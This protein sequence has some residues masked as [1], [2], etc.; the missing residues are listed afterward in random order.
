MRHGNRQNTDNRE[1]P[2]PLN[3]TL[4]ITDLIDLE[5]LQSLQDNF[6][7]ATGVASIIT[8]PD[9]TPI[10]K[11][12]NFCRLCNDI[13]RKTEKGCTNCR[14][15]DAALGQKNP[16]GPIMQ[17]CLSGGLWDGG[18]SIS[19]GNRHIA[20]WLI[21]QV[22]NSETPR[23]KL[24]LYADEIGADREEFAKAV[25]EVTVMSTEQFGR[26]CSALFV[27]AN[28]ISDLA[29]KNL[30]LRESENNLTATLKSIGDAVITTDERGR[31][32]MMNPVAEAITGWSSSDAKDR[33]VGDILPIT[34]AFTGKP[35]EDP[36]SVVLRTNAAAAIPK[37]S[38]I[39]DRNGVIRHLSDSAAPIH[40]PDGTI[41]GVVI[42]L[43]DVSRE[44]IME[45]QL[46]QSQKMD[47][48]GRLAGGIAHD[49]NNMLAGIRGAADLLFRKYKNDASSEKL[50]GIILEA[51]ER[52]ASL[53]SKMLDFSRKGKKESTPIDMHDLISRA[54]GILERSVDK[55]ISIESGLDAEQ[56]V[57]SGDPSQL[58]SVIINL[59]INA[60]DAMP[61]GGTIRISTG[62]V[63]ICRLSTHLIGDNAVP[64][65]Y[66]EICISDTG[67][68]IPRAIREKIFDPF[69]TTKETGKG[70]GLGLSV[71][72]G[73]I[74]DHR[75]SINVYS[76]EGRGSVFKIYLPLLS[77]NS[78]ATEPLIRE[79]T[80]QCRVGRILLV[81]D[82]PILRSTGQLMLEELGNE[83]VSAED[84]VQ[85]VAEI[86]GRN[87]RGI[88]LV[89]MDMIMPNMNGIEAY[90]RISDAFPEIPFIFT[91]GFTYDQSLDEITMNRNVVDFIRKPYTLSALCEALEKTKARSAKPGA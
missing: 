80:G 21:G 57:I 84:G 28:H 67:T 22:R 30:A 74:T 40:N 35:A 11:P 69:F 3:D 70:T 19:V 12:G 63:E 26:V 24:M 44:M 58:L 15:S 64:G 2:R 66:L 65:R 20:N 55:K 25:D 46:R 13:I 83:V 48:I 59:G 38:V 17:P 33:P 51:A 31:I 4:R 10:T 41:S 78:K 8:D 53:T 9:G 49:F 39:L 16:S 72:Y 76:E 52:A 86:D 77:E 1:D 85:A 87:G 7:S 91:S 50:I 29:Y 88:D 75:G 71:V 23:E 43:R 79:F 60:R 89:V 34:D 6:A 18:A 61:D 42:V 37:N 54:V 68:G 47:A 82:E 62:T 56:F 73:T 27:F 14:K 90:R 5:T 36:A 45:E 32:T 81:D